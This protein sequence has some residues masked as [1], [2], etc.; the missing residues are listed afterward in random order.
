MKKLVYIAGSECA[1]GTGVAKKIR[2]EMKAFNLHGIE[3]EVVYV[4][5]LPKWKKALPFS[6]SFD[7]DSVDVRNADYLYI[8]W[9]PVSAPFL[10]FLKRCRQNNPGIRTVM[11]I[12]TYPYLDELK[13][14]VRI[15]E[16][17]HE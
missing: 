12:P 7:W 14:L 5:E 8:R 10:R 11:E 1:G 3:T 16:N 2:N 9:E 13:K 4:Q 15:P 17:K 6:S